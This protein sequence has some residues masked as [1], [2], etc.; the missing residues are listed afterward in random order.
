[1]KSSPETHRLGT[2]RIR[3]VFQVWLVATGL[4]WGLHNEG[5]S[6]ISG[7][8]RQRRDAWDR[9]LDGGRTGVYRDNAYDSVFQFVA[10]G[11]KNAGL[12]GA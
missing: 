12:W 2:A 10:F 3:A 1:M 11:I 7:R 9:Q 5:S 4:T 6:V 8:L